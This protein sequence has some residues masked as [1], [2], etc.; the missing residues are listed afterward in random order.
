MD[1]NIDDSLLIEEISNKEEREEGEE[2]N[3]KNK[4]NQNNNQHN[5]KNSDRD[6]NDNHHSY[7]SYEL[8][9][10]AQSESHFD[11]KKGSSFEEDHQEQQ[12]QLHFNSE[13]NIQK[14]SLKSSSNKI[15]MEQHQ[16]TTETDPS[17]EQQKQLDEAS[18]Q[19]F[20]SAGS[21]TATPIHVNPTSPRASVHSGRLT[22]RG[23]STNRSQTNLSTVRSLDRY[24][25]TINDLKYMGDQFVVGKLDPTLKTPFEVRFQNMYKKKF[26]KTS[27]NMDTARSQDQ[28]FTL[29]EYRRTKDLKSLA[30]P[31]LHT[32]DLKY[33]GDQFKVGKLDPKQQHPFEKRFQKKFQQKLKI[34][35][36][37][38]ESG[39]KKV[40]CFEELKEI[41][42]TLKTDHTFYRI[43]K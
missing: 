7:S 2:E 39:P 11:L 14:P 30:N 3:S 9:N 23:Q 15:I 34:L 24:L 12:E 1:D 36:A 16:E 18:K 19:P 37:D 42:N 6:K 5:Q 22:Q 13:Q 20:K 4:N 26:P 40:L 21:R 8:Q 10:L 28:N 17:N 32:N 27:D 33:T 43:K 29:S 38:P 31:L 35:S 41:H 25:T